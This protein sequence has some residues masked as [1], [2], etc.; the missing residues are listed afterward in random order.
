MGL[1]SKGKYYNSKFKNSGC[2]SIGKLK[3]RGM[4]NGNFIYI[5]FYIILS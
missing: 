4:V 2:R 1:D 3:R 5:C